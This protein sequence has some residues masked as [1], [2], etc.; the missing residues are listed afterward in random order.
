MKVPIAVLAFAATL[1]GAPAIVAAQPAD[2]G[3]VQRFE[4]DHAHT[5][6]GFTARHM[7]VTNVR[8]SF[9]SFRGHIDLDTEDLTRSKVFVEIDVASID[10]NNQR[11][12]DHLR[13]DDF[14]DAAEYPTITFLGERVE[15]DGDELILHGHLTIRD[16]TRPV[17]IPFE[18]TG[19]IVAG[20]RPR[21]GAEGELRIDRFDYG[22]QWSNTMET[23]GLVVGPEIRIL[24]NVTA[25]GPR[26]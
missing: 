25:L 13:S 7:M 24:L 3:T 1:L 23:G 26:D 19:P 12:D 15:Q 9:N 18:M 22:V 20:G 5:N 2:G 8:G 21:L 11:R 10:T 6:I 14:F 4:L 16:V 17:A